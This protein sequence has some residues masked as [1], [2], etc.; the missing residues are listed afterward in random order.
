M[1]PKHTGIFGLLGT[2]PSVLFIFSFAFPQGL[3]AVCVAEV[4]RQFRWRRGHIV[5]NPVN[6][7][8]ALLGMK[9]GIFQIAVRAVDGKAPFIE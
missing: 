2:Q 8:I 7:G 1:T 3:Q 9:P 5:E 6:M 4:A